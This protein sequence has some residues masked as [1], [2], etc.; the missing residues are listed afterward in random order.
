MVERE[1]PNVLV[2]IFEK[3]GSLRHKFLTTVGRGVSLV[4][5]S[6]LILSVEYNI[7]FTGQTFIIRKS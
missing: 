3:K 1:T 5:P 6:I 2:K 7:V 4:E